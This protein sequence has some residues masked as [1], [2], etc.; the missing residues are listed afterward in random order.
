MQNVIRR[1]S[2]NAMAGV[3]EIMDSARLP[4]PIAKQLKDNRDTLNGHEIR[5]EADRSDKRNARN[6]RYELERNNQLEQSILVV[7][8]TFRHQPSNELRHAYYP[9][10]SW[11]SSADGAS[12]LSIPTKGGSTDASGN[13]PAVLYAETICP[14]CA[15]T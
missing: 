4:P 7:A 9:V 13:A 14:A 8:D 10:T 5:A 12:G 3:H 11:L 6:V 1:R 2:V 15:L